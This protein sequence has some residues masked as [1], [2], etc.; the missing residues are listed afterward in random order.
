MKQK[1]LFL[2][3]LFFST[4]AFSQLQL[5]IDVIVVDFKSNKKESGATLK[6]YE[7]STVVG[8]ATSGSNGKIS[9]KVPANKVYKVEVSKAGKVTRFFTV[10]SKNIDIE[11]LQ[12]ASEPM[13]RTSISLF[14]KTNNVDYSFIQTNPI[15]E[16]YFDGKSTA[17][18]YNKSTADKMTKKVE[19]VIAQAEKTDGNNEVQYQAKM[20]EG[21][22]A[23][24]ASNYLEARTKFEQAQYFKP[25]D[26]LSIK[27]MDD[28]DKLVKA[29]KISQIDGEVAGGAYDN[30]IQAA[31][32][33][34]S[35]KK[36]QLAIDKYE[37]ALKSK[38]RDQFALD[39][40]DDLFDL[41]QKEKR[42]KANESAYA[43]AMSTGE[44]L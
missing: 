12:G 22:A 16:F 11:L 36:Y 3:I 2:F 6:V 7:G 10:N 32:T 35:Q 25:G 42:D 33:L 28:M 34:K 38:P 19:E 18:A 43:A 9:L 41:I 24:A 40:I 20:K 23:A 29:D 14:D 8:S 27:R 31:K 4:T 30:L 13:V 21:E 44:I 17:L 1:L 5:D 26:K 39:E 37:E 15:T